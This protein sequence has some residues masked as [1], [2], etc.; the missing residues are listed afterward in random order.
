MRLSARTGILLQFVTNFHL[1]QIEATNGLLPP[2]GKA[3]MVP[4]SPQ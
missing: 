3:S 4:T 2:K 1:V